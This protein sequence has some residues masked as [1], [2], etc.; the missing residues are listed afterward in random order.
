V[1]LAL[2]GKND[3]VSR[4]LV[5]ALHLGNTSAL[6]LAMVGAA[7]L[8]RFPER[9]RLSLFADPEQTH[10]VPTPQSTVMVQSPFWGLHVYWLGAL[11]IVLVSAAGAVTALGD[12]VYPVGARSSLEVAR[13]LS[14]TNGHFLE[15]LRG[16]HPLFAGL[17]ATFWVFVG[18]RLE[19]LWGRRI[20]LVC[21]LQ[22]GAGLVNIYLSAPGWMQ[23]IHLALANLLWLVWIL[24]WLTRPA[25]LPLEQAGLAEESK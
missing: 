10:F 23:V 8:T 18:A 17:A 21:L 7:Y 15:H 6:L 24:A 20:V 11:L 2:V 22:V 9:T 3:S 1:L 4:A 12:T 14:H 13:Q 25:S 19:S 16:V 5:M